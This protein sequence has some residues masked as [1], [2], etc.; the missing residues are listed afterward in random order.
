MTHQQGELEN[1]HRQS[2]NTQTPHTASYYQHSDTSGPVQDTWRP[3]GPALQRVQCSPQASG[4]VAMGRWTSVD[5]S[6]SSA[7]ESSSAQFYQNN[8]PQPFC[9]PTTPGLSPH[10]PQ[11]PTIPSPQIHPKEERPDF[12]TQTSGQLSSDKTL[13]CL[14]G[15]G[16]YPRIS[17]PAQHHPHQTSQHHF[18]Q[19]SELIQDQMGVLDT[20]RNSES[21]FSL[22]VRGQEVSSAAQAPALP[23]QLSCRDEH[24]GGGG[25]RGGNVQPDLTRVCVICILIVILLFLKLLRKKGSLQIS[26]TVSVKKEE[27]EHKSVSK[28]ANEHMNTKK[29][30][31]SRVQKMCS[32]V[33]RQKI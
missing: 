16:S 15:Y 7:E 33:E 31:C 25:G 10:Y 30:M 13:S 14:H 8:A 6:S 12:H 23:V 26:K 20:I 9:R 1:A 21:Y 5:F 11:T 29:Q 22:Q 32:E 4:E 17:D 28:C 27:K 24:G 3:P 2:Y 19:Q 18:L